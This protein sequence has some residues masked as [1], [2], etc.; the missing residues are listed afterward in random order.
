MTVFS[1]RIQSYH[2]VIV[3]CSSSATKS[4]LWKSPDCISAPSSIKSKDELMI[5]IEISA[6]EKRTISYKQYKNKTVEEIIKDIVP[7]TTSSYFFIYSTLMLFPTDPL[8]IL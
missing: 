3:Q 4:K 2:V 8:I 5:D 1:A 6:T 7:N